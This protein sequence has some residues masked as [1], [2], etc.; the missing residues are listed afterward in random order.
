MEENKQEREKYIKNS[1]SDSVV[2]AR[3][4]KEEYKYFVLDKIA[5]AGKAGG[6]GT[7]EVYLYNEQSGIY[8]FIDAYRFDCLLMK[9]LTKYELTKVW[10]ANRLAEIKRAFLSFGELD[11]VE[12]DSYDNLLCLDN[13]ILNLDTYDVS[14]YSPSLYFRTKISVAYD[15]EIKSAP[16]FVDFLKSCFINRHGE[17]DED[18]VTNLIRIGGYLLYPKNKLRLMFLFLGE[19]SNG[20]S[21]LMDIYSM[22]FSEANIS[23]LDL[24]TISSL[25]LEREALINSRIN[26]TTEAKSSN[27]NAEMIKKIISSEGIMITRKN[28]LAVAYRPITKII[29]A[30]NINPYFNDTT[31]GIYR[32][33]FPVTFGNRFEPLNEYQKHTRPELKNIY[34]AKDEDEMRANFRAEKSAILNMFLI[35]LKSLRDNGWQLKKTFN[36]QAAMEDYKSS[37]DTIGF[38][39][40]NYYEEMT[41]EERKLENIT[42]VSGYSADEVLAYYRE[43]YRHNVMDKALNFSVQSMGKK[44][45]ELFRCDSIRKYTTDG[46]RATY[47]LIKKKNHTEELNLP[48][49]PEQES[50]I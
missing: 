34:L 20:K 14:P 44:I 7:P 6:S 43:W 37:S 48:K 1:A 26:I 49:A 30:S 10:K 11:E 42:D 47:Y 23:Y 38:F 5:L 12:F 8:N 18:T 25:G 45:K 15:K 39:L 29:V 27:M 32:R 17:V 41:E 16:N 36:S 28:R 9:F 4:F 2:L 31:H 35:G 24:D 13:G 3:A 46:D 40:S 19:G 22:F 21:L 33:I 50:F